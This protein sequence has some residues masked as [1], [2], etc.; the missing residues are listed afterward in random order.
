MK[1]HLSATLELGGR[2]PVL[3][4]E[5]G[6]TIQLS[7]EEAAGWAEGERLA[8]RVLPEEQDVLDQ[9][10]LGRVLLNELIKTDD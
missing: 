1:L 5:D 7:R 8:L 4:L 6:Q 2:H 10:E 3:R 9:Q